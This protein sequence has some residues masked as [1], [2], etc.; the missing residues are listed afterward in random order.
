MPPPGGEGAGWGA[1][2]G[3]GV[4]AG[5]GAGTGPGAGATGAG[6][7]PPPPPQPANAVTTQVVAARLSMVHPQVP[8]RLGA[9]TAMDNGPLESF[10]ELPCPA[11]RPCLPKPPR[12]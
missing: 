9:R 5:V 1:G 10:P 6:S 12:S 2:A 8:G 7:G 4:G 11:S 3:A